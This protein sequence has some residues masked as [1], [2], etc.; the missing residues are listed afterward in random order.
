MPAP[1][2]GAYAALLQVRESCGQHVPEALGAVAQVRGELPHELD[3]DL[4]LPSIQGF[5]LDAFTDGSVDVPT[6]PE[7]ALAGAATWAADF[8][9]DPLLFRYATEV[10]MQEGAL[11]FFSSRAG[12]IAPLVLRRLRAFLPSLLRHR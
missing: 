3:F 6:W 2:A 4:N 11:S 9:G 5:T 8:Q 10:P 1:P 12:C 7:Y